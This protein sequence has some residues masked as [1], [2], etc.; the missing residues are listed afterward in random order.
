MSKLFP[1]RARPFVGHAAF[2]TNSHHTAPSQAALLLHLG[3]QLRG[4]EATRAARAGAAKRKSF[5]A[6]GPDDDFPVPTLRGFSGPVAYEDSRD[7]LKRNH[8]YELRAV[9]G[10][11]QAEDAYAAAHRDCAARLFEQP[12]AKHAADLFAISLDHPFL[13][14]RIAAAIASLPLSTRP[15][16]NVRVLVQGLKSEDL[17][18][19]TLAATGLA[20]HHPE[21][22]ALRPLARGKTAPLVKTKPETLLLVHGTWASDAAW[23]QPNGDLFNFLQG[24][25]ADLYS[26]SD[27]FKWSGGWSDGARFAGATEL[28]QWVV[29]RNEAGL[30]LMGHSHGANII[31]KA[32]TMGL[33]AGKAVLLSCP[34]HVDKYFPD[35]NQ[36]KRPVQSVR[37]KH[38]LVILADGGGQQF[39]HPD[40]NELV[41]PIWFDHGASHDPAVWQKNNVAGKIKL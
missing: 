34:V 14:V 29:A 8:G 1:H 21:H 23:Y 10:A 36:L 27:Y 2:A 15:A 12:M 19:R 32:T 20:R 5:V 11:A 3:N 40:I 26:K 22:A 39:D 31:L 33:T 35:F 24:S 6:S 13:L 9:P 4:T 18:E 7:R 16:H 41:L 25:R 37:V 38:D 30:D 28:Q 17:L